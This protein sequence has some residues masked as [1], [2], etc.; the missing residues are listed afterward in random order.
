MLSIG[1]LNGIYSYA[2]ATEPTMNNSEQAAKLRVFTSYSINDT[3]WFVSLSDIYP[4]EKGVLKPD[5]DK[6]E[7]RRTY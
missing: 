6:D 2:S 1:L 3:T 5:N 7:F 4:Y